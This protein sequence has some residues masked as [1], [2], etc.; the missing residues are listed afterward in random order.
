MLTH[1][2]LFK[3]FLNIVDTIVQLW[4]LAGEKLLIDY[5]YVLKR[6]AE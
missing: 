5:Y 4:H 6:Y 1:L 2:I 3:C